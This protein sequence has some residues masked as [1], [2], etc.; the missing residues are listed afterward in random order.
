MTASA[1]A[2]QPRARHYTDADVEIAAKALAA[3][4][5]DQC[6]DFDGPQW[7]GTKEVHRMDARAVL[8]ALTAAD[9]LPL[10]TR[11]TGQQRRIT[12]AFAEAADLMHRM[13]KDSDELRALLE[14]TR[15]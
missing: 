9:R 2:P 5:G 14:A 6:F 8:D 11:V 1:A 4:R 3:T 10:L 12:S 13:A 15:D 7:D